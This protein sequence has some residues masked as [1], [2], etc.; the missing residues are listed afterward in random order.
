MTMTKKNKT[1]LIVLSAVLVLCLIF[2]GLTFS[3][4]FVGK[5]AGGLDTGNGAPLS[6]VVSAEFKSDYPLV[7]TQQENIFYEA[8]PDGNIKYFKFSD[9]EFIEITNVKSKKITVTCSYQKVDM[10]I[11]YLED[12]DVG[13]IGYGLFSVKQKSDVK[14]F[15]YIFARM[16]DC[17]SSYKDSA[18]TAYVLLLDMDAEDAYKAEKTYS[19]IYSFD[20]SSGTTSLIMSSRDR[21]VQEDATQNENWTI[22]TDASVNSMSKYDWFASTRYHDTG[23]EKVLYDFMS[24]ESSRS[25]KKASS[26]EF[27]DS[28]SYNIWEKDGS[29]YFFADKDD[30]FSLVKNGDKDKPLKEFSGSFKDYAV[31]GHFILDLSSMDFTDVY[32][33]ET[34]SVKKARLNSFSG[35]IAS[36]GGKS[37][38]VFC[39]GD[40][41][42]MIIYDTENNKAQIISDSDIFNSGICNYCFINNKTVIVSN[43]AEDGTAL[44]RVVKL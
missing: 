31:S 33:G 27:V 24:V 25:T 1:V 26:T 35:F 36:P 3:K 5:L 8:Y 9:N 22:F 12:T 42:A 30:G 11:H 28:P 20:M 41:Q 43:Y 10:T 39:G 23:A 38:V 37:F 18:R 4:G 17:P 16:I 19:D 32:T 13:T 21:T 34:I 44:N 2:A 40:K 7:Q 14:S 6:S 29:V 15:S